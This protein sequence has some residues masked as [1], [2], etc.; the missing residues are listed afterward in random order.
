MLKNFPIDFVRQI[1]EQGLLEE[2]IKNPSKYF[3][4]KNQL[5]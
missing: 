5:I 2:H 3:G 1:I 4:G